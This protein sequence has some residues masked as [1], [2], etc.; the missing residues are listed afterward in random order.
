MKLK[1]ITER[2]PGQVENFWGGLFWVDKQIYFENF[3][4]LFLS[5]LYDV[6]HR[7]ER[8]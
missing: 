3:F 4:Y 2:F 5:I 8:C 1:F 6:S 7:I